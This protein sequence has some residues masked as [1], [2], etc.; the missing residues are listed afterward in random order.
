MGFTGVFF[1]I[2]AKFTMLSKGNYAHLLILI[3]KLD[4]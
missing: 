4:S 3:K 1:R 2:A